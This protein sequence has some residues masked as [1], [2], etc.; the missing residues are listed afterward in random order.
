MRSLGILAA[1]I[2]FFSV[3]AEAADYVYDLGIRNTDITFS[4]GTI[5]AGESVRIYARVTNYGTKDISGY[6]TFYQGERL[7][8]DSQ[9]VTVRSDS[10][11][12]DVWVDFTIPQGAFNIRAEIKGTSPQDQNPS[13][14][15]AISQTFY[16]EPDKDG[17]LIPDSQD[18]CKD[19]ANP[20][21]ADRDHDGIGDVCDQYPDDPTNTPPA[22]PGNGSNSN[23]N[24]NGNTN[25]NT[26][27]NA[28]LPVNQPKPPVNTNTSANSNSNSNV[29][30]PTEGPGTD[31]GFGLV[32]N[33]T[34]SPANSTTTVDETS[35]TG[36][37]S[38]A[39][40]IS[41]RRVG[42]DTFDFTAV[43]ETAGRKTVFWNFGDGESGAGESVRH[44]FKK[45]GDYAVKAAIT[46]E[47]GEVSETS[48]RVSISFFNFGNWKLILVLSGILL[49]AII[50]GILA[51]RAGR[52]EDK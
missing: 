41:V 42:W 46:S 3:A 27:Q 38:G 25:R 34:S 5:V 21:Q 43:S 39:N 13:N 52:K 29:N 2:M 47:R 16:P 9:V 50:F 31:T 48:A 45:T 15:V 44:R 14:D 49:A 6:V 19:I 28:N 23:S 7:I 24:T 40:S 4:K 18:N 1:A 33:S 37:E 10:S 51:A 26:N 20:D 17:D 32:N 22:P 35:S 36:G 12:D 8:G 30:S 11:Y